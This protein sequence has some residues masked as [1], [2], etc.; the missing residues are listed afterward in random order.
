MW[1]LRITLALA[2]GFGLT[3][4]GAAQSQE[5]VQAA[6]AKLIELAETPNVEPLFD[7][8]V[9][10][11]ALGTMPVSPLPERM[12]RIA[13]LLEGKPGQEALTGAS[14][15]STSFTVWLAVAD[16]TYCAIRYM[17]F[18]KD[19]D[20]NIESLEGM[21]ELVAS[22]LTLTE[23]EREQRSKA[24]KLE[25]SEVKDCRDTGERLV[26]SLSPMEGASE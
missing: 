23:E 13:K 25:V 8:E 15:P 2:V 3:V 9:Y 11:E 19:F 21:L 24:V 7:D 22:D 4:P 1:T 5:E 18:K 14:G 20:L 12:T 17:L 26:G 10:L 16:D 6:Q